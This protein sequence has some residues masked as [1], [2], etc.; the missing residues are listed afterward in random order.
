MNELE[1]LWHK[2]EG[3]FVF[4]NIELLVTSAYIMAQPSSVTHRNVGLATL[5][6]LRR[7]YL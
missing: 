4:R 7:R 2:R 6:T 1:E 3:A 5:K